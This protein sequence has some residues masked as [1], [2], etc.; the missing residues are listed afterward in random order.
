MNYA[1]IPVLSFPRY[2][3]VPAGKAGIQPFLSDVELNMM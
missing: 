2:E 3:V 1:Q